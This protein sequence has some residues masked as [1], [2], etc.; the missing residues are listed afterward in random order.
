[1]SRILVNPW[2]FTLFAWLLLMTVIGPEPATVVVLLNL[3]VVIGPMEIV[4]IATS[5]KEERL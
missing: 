3:A 4:G 5:S 2:L 1:M